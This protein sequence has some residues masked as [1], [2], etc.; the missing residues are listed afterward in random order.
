MFMILIMTV[1]VGSLNIFTPTEAIAKNLKTHR[2]ESEHSM[3]SAIQTYVKG[4]NTRDVNKLKHVFHEHF[5][6]VA[7]TAEGIRKLDR[8]T[9]L[10]LITAGEIGGSDRKLEIVSIG[11]NEKVATAKVL[12]HGEQ[13]IFHDTL[14]FL[15][16]DNRWQLV[17][18][19]TWVEPRE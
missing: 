3:I 18:N 14:T 16:E 2:I 15:K 17:S 4:A 1:F 13:V 10:D 12:L 5:Q 11:E 6:V 7:I 19:V 9:Y 8:E